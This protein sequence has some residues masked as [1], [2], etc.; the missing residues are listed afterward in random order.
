MNFGSLFS[1]IGGFD[2]GFECAG[3]KCAWQCEI[4]PTCQKVLEKHWPEVKRYGDIRTIGKHNLEPVDVICGGF[5]CQPHSLAGK[6]K[7]SKDERDLWPEFYRIICEIEPEWVVAEN[8]RGVL[9]SE[10]GRF[11]GGILKDLAARGY[12]VE[13]Q[14]LSAEAFGAPHIRERVFVVANRQSSGKRKLPVST[15][16]SLEESINPNGIRKDVSNSNGE[17]L[18]ERYESRGTTSQ[19]RRIFARSEF[20]RVYTADRS[21]QWA[22]EPAICRVAHGIPGRVDRLK[23]LGN[24]VVP[25]VA[26]WIGRRIVE[27]TP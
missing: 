27:V 5:P 22:I 8:V 23:Q 12:D 6:R 25:Q 7:A 24:A 19:T 13:W 26:E 16:G 17:G 18:S 10:S 9:S 14:V 2:R 1:G 3:M 15:W 11:F 21:Q 20:E 4:D